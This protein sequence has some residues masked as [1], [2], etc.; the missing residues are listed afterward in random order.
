VDA[1][2]VDLV[3]SG[4]GAPTRRRSDG[5][6]VRRTPWRHAGVQR[7]HSDREACGVPSVVGLVLGGV[8]RGG[9]GGSQ[10]SDVDDK[11][12]TE[13]I[14]RIKGVLTHDVDMFDAL[15]AAA[16]RHVARAVHNQSALAGVLEGVLRKA[17][18]HNKEIID[19]LSGV[20]YLRVVAHCY[21]VIERI[22]GVLT[23]DVDMFDALLAAAPRHVAR[24]VHNQSALAGV[25]EGVLRKAGEHNKEIID[26]FSGVIYL[27][28][29]A[30][31]YDPRWCVC[32]LLQYLIQSCARGGRRI[33]EDMWYEIRRAEACV[34]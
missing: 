12:K 22:K 29:G 32:L 30:R 2:L 16:P 31:C 26:L 4:R 20:L 9:G 7:T 34:D 1:Q 33:V 28:V 13:V 21:D 3:H 18:E 6:R 14:E 23:H 5:Q 25:L 8:G 17:G 19:L 24:A 10:W 15:L 27:R 11:V